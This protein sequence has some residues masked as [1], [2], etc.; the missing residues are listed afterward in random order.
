MRTPLS[1]SFYESRDVVSLARQLVG[2][3]IYTDFGCLTGGIITETEAY[4]GISDRASH[5][6]GGK[7]TKR[8]ESMYGPPGI[9]YIY[10]CYGIHYMLNV[11]TAEE[12]TPH[13]I[14]IRAIRPIQGIEMM[15]QRR[16]K[17]TPD[18]TLTIGPGK[19]AAAL[20]I[21]CEHNG[22][23][24]DTLPLLI[25]DA[26]TASQIEASERIGVDYAGEDAKLLYRFR[27]LEP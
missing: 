22:I 10:L 12:N 14:L 3:E 1:R 24:F 17:Q 27:L 11:V 5:A 4:A 18:E 25:C 13:A 15:L 21:T 19:T 16:K 26:P 23:S 9:A 8:N 2:K 6:F 7:R 20:G